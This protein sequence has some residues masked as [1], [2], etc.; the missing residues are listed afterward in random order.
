[1]PAHAKR[2]KSSTPA[3][4]PSQ[5]VR[6]RPDG[7]AHGPPPPHPRPGSTHRTPTQQQTSLARVQK[8]KKNT[9]AANKPQKKTAAR[10]GC[11]RRCPRPSRGVAAASLLTRARV[12]SRG[13]RAPPPQAAPVPVTPIS[14][15][16]TL[17]S[18]APRAPASYLFERR[19]VASG[20][21]SD[22]R[23]HSISNLL[24]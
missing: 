4:K 14:S 15:T 23:S 18:A 13:S 5:A 3:K 16:R 2:A 6:R 20:A 22:V 21:S 24:S 19:G 10:R 9:S 11:Q 1:M 7:A 12:L 17:S 8:Q